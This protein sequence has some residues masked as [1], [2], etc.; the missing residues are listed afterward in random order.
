MSRK[1]I[2]TGESGVGSG[3]GESREKNEKRRKK[4]A[5]LGVCLATV[6]S[7]LALGLL[8]SPAT[9]AAGRNP[10]IELTEEPTVGERSLRAGKNSTD[11]NNYY[12]PIKITATDIPL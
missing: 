4:S 9:Y 1:G 3:Y 2:R 8:F 12:I 6:A 5:R 11:S 10:S 7:T